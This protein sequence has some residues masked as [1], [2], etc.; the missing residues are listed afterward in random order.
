MFPVSNERVA[1]VTGASRGIGRGI[2]IELARLG[3]RIGINYAGNEAAADECLALV[4]AA[5]GDG[6]TLQADISKHDDRERL[7]DSTLS[8]LGGIDLL[9]NNAGV[10]PSVRADIL[11]ATEESFDRL[12][13]INLKG[14]YFL[15]QRVAREMIT[16]NATGQIV[17]ITS[18]SAYTASVNRGDY[19]ISKAG[20]GMMTALWA[21]RLAEHGIRVYEIRPGVIATD[22]TAGVKEKY[23]ALIADGAWAL[24]RWGLP[25]DIGRAVAAIAREDFP[26]STGEVFNVDGGFHLRTL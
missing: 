9:V 21:A 2:A 20:L 24:K 3:W 4:R 26:F 11:E 19:C 1:L 15:T 10:A 13:D 6:V 18:L 7:V 25:E 8:T 22:M 23:D 17:T 5:G 12:I 16:R 14:P